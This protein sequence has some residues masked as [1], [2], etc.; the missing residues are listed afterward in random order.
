MNAYVLAL[1]IVAAM[2][3]A[4]QMTASGQSAPAD[5]PASAPTSTPASGPADK[6]VTVEKT[7]AGD[8]TIQPVCH[9]AVRFA[10]K[11][12]QYYVDPSGKVE[13]D[14]MPKADAIFVTHEHGDHLDPK[15]IDQIKKDGT[16]IY[17]NPASVAKAGFGEKIEAGQKKTVLD[18]TVEAVPAYNITP[19]RSGH[20]KGRDN[21]YVLTFGDKRVYVAGDSEGTPEMEALKDIDIA[22]LPIDGTYTMGP[23]DAAEAARAFK[24]KVLYLYHENKS[25]P[26]EVKALLADEKAIEVRVLP[27]P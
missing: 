18:I 22:F 23:K 16:V 1:G 11:G 15:A 5:K 27:L 8:L 19:G 4:C 10:F 3:L 21:G 7:A 12:K 17:A 9:A 13:W 26:A 2:I 20:P 6:N 24:P 25:D 14:K